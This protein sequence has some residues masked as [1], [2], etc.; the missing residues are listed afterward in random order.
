MSVK[1]AEHAGTLLLETWLMV[2]TNEPRIQTSEVLRRAAQEA[3]TGHI[4]ARQY[5]S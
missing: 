1:T 5:V 4:A 2:N 3:Q